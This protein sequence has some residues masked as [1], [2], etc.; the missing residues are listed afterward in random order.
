M[1]DP[2]PISFGILGSGNMARV[3]GDALTTQ[4]PGGR[5]AAI[6]LGTARRVAWPPST[7]VAA[8]PA[9]DA[10]LARQDVDVVVIA[11]PHSTHLPLALQAAAA[12]KHVYLE[13]PMALDIVECQQIIDACRSAGVLLTVARQSRHNEMTSG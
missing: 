10:L 6:A 13:K 11:T 8:E 5:L 4:V 7:G 9:V 12:G 3:Y 1:T 2:Q